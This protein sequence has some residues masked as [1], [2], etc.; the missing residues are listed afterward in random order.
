MQKSL[1][2]L[3]SLRL[4]HIVPIAAGAYL[5]SMARLR[6]RAGHFVR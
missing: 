4:L 3:Q 5:W 1:K 2:M 6:E